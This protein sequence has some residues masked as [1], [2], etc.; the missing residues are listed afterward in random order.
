MSEKLNQLVE[1]SE[2]LALNPGAFSQINRYYNL[3][4]KLHE[5]KRT[6]VVKWKIKRDRAR[7]NEIKYS[8][9]AK[10]KAQAC[11]RTRQGGRFIKE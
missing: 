3:F 7:K 4:E 2:V 8:P 6:S 9:S 10:R 1:A 11:A 5:P